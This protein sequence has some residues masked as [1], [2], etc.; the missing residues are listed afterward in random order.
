MN[1][2]S[3]A[4]VVVCLAAVGCSG[5]SVTVG[6]GPDGKTYVHSEGGGLP[7]VD[8]T[9]GEK[10]IEAAPTVTPGQPTPVYPI[11]TPAPDPTRTPRMSSAVI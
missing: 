5:G 1:R 6:S 11:D 8:A 3:I 9:V 2:T 7:P 10:G 4:G